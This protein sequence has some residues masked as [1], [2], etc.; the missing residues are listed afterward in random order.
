MFDFELINKNLS[1]VEKIINSNYNFN[2]YD[3]KSDDIKSCDIMLC[4]VQARIITEGLCRYI[5]LNEHI[6]NDEKSIRTATLKVY[7]DDLLR[8]NLL[9]PKSII[10][11]LSTIQGISN[12][13]V[14]FQTDGHQNRNQ[15]VICLESLQ[16]VFEWFISRYG[17]NSQKLNSWK[18]SSDSLNKSGLLPEKAEGC[19]ISRASEIDDI[20][21]IVLLNKICYIYGCTGVG[22]TEIVKDYVKKYRKKYDGVYY[23]E[24]VKEIKDFVYNL[25]IG[26]LNENSKTKE[27][28]VLEKIEILHSMGLS[29]LF[30][31]DNYTGNEKDIDCLIPYGEDKYHLLIVS[32]D[33]HCISEEEYKYKVNP[34]S[35]DDS[36]RIFRFFCQY[37][38][39]DQEINGLLE[40]I[41]YN[42]RAIKMSA[43]F[44]NNSATFSPDTLVREMKENMS[45][46]SMIQG[47][48]IVLTKSSI[49][50]RD[51][52]VKRICQYLSLL[53]YNGV[54]EKRF[55]SLI[56]RTDVKNEDDI[57]NAIEQLLDAGWFSVDS[58][59]YISI[60]PLISDTLFERTKPD[61][62]STNVI[63]FLEPILSP[64]KE[65]RE[66]FMPQVVALEPYVEHLYNRILLSKHCNL[67]ILNEIR[68]YYIATYDVEKIE[69]LNGLMK[70]EYNNYCNIGGAISIE[71]VIFRQ[72]ISRFNFEDFQE[73]HK[74]FSKALEMLYQKKVLIE[75]DIAKISAYEGSSLAAIGEEKKAIECVEVSIEL[76]EK[77]KKLGDYDES[78]RLWISHY[79]YAKILLTLKRF[80]EAEK[81]CDLSMLL[82][83]E[84]FPEEYENKSS[85]NVSSLFQLKGRICTGLGN[86]DD[87]IMFLE[88]AKEIRE[89]LKGENYFSTA[90]VYYYLMETYE[91]FGEDEKA[92]VYAKKYYLALQKQCR[93]EEVK[94]KMEFVQNKIVKIEEKILD[95]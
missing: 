19:L 85:T 31:I 8:P 39:T 65:I 79:N 28:V 59:G 62:L 77:M 90:Q 14:H 50:E 44:L 3:L 1:E 42:P 56:K 95:A 22:K 66:L 43:V 72:G 52:I 12:L 35:P 49:I 57:N 46:K 92:I 83:S 9:V 17:M 24:N 89:K 74:S 60:N 20:R 75:K 48:Y 55:I 11:N 34:F 71:N 86:K 5:V 6:V 76:R 2:F 82:Y 81:E 69:K 64:I 41:N 88:V 61:M 87:A 15:A 73:A 30:I 80:L 10:S 33:S 32:D 16:Q 84:S 38:Y 70:Q 58:A 4:I 93:T 54:S 13:S 45:V 91:L 47:L 23:S 53:P 25:P 40:Y 26:I 51:A 27:D 94:K 78:K 18:I 29:Y 7:V 63:S 36:L 21:R 68:E 37:K 67:D